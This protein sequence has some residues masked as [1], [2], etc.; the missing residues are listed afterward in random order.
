MANEQVS[1]KRGLHANLPST[2]TS[3][4]ILV[5]TDTGV[6]YIDDSSTSR[7]QIKDPTKLPI[8]SG[9][10]NKLLSENG[11]YTYP[12]PWATATY[13]TSLGAPSLDVTIPLIEFESGEMIIV[14]TPSDYPSSPAVIFLNVNGQG[15]ATSDNMID[16]PKLSANTAYILLYTGSGWKVC[17]QPK[18][19]AGTGLSISG[20]TI[21]HASYGTAGTYG[22]SANATLTWSGTFTV[23]YVTT[24]AQGHITGSGVRTFTMPANP[25][26]DTKVTQSASISTNG[27]YPVLLGYSTATT[28]VT[29]TVNKSSKLLF[30]PSTGKLTATTIDATI[31]DGSID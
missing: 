20:N 28:A 1:I 24:N 3:G 7:I 21:S 5:E 23:P 13:S 8:P 15:S 17:G 31:D 9:T 6:M 16:N 4:Q 19:S 27:N 30:N 18:I 2:K 12:M 22:P 29:N 26:V 11:L 14:V 25:N 10:S